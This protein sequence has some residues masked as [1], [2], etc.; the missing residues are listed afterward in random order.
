MVAS[1]LAAGCTFTLPYNPLKP[2][3]AESDVQ[4]FVDAMHDC[5]KANLGSDGTLRSWKATS[6]GSDV[7]RVQYT[8][9]NSS[10]GGLLLV[11]FK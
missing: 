4:L 11:I 6:Q 1:S 3:A 10:S 7:S 8:I 9:Y 5:V 2:F